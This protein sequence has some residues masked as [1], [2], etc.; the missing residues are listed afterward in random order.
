MAT[1]ARRAASA[2]AWILLLGLSAGAAPRIGDADAL[3]GRWS[4]TYKDGQG[5]MHKHVLDV[6]GAGDKIAATERRD[7]EPAV[8]VTDLKITDKKVTFSVLRDERRA[9]YT[10]TLKGKDAD[11]IEGLVV[12]SGAGESHEYGWEAK[13]EPTKK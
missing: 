1:I 12:I 7:D 2:F 10:G 4:W 13:K 9:A 3:V 6:E 11:L 5:M 8:K